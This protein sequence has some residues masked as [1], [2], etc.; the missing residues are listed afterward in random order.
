MSDVPPILKLDTDC[1]DEIFE[2][3]S[4]PDLQSI[5][6]T[7]KALQKAAGLYFWK[8]FESTPKFVESNGIEMPYN[9]EDGPD[10]IRIT[11]GFHQFLK[12]I[13]H[14]YPE[15]ETIEYNKNHNQNFESLNEILLSRYMLDQNIVESLKNILPKI[16]ILRLCGCEIDGDFYENF[17]QF[18]G[19]LK[20]IFVSLEVDKTKHIVNE[21]E[22]NKWMLRKYPTI[23]VFTIETQIPF[24]I[25]ELCWFLTENSTIQTFATTAKM[26]WKNRH[27]LLKSDI[28]LDKLEISMIFED[29]MKM[30]AELLNQLYEI[31]FYKRLKCEISIRDPKTVH[32]LA[33]LRGFKEIYILDLAAECDFS[34]L[35]HLNSLELSD[36][37]EYKRHMNNMATNL[38]NL[39][40]LII[41]EADSNDILPFI[42]RSVKLK[43]IEI[44]S[45][46]GDL[47]LVQLNNE[48]E[49]LA[50]AQ[51]LIIYI[52]DYAFLKTK[53]TITNGNTNLSKIELRRGSFYFFFQ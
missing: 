23:K 35:A 3:L 6:Q 1:C 10:F 4:V 49:K 30:Y 15:P 53:W 25:N 37:Y 22:E 2:Y 9:T 38:V 16:E 21:R 11:T 47:N 41:G 27:E 43:R 28:K 50:D 40:N 8:C 45:F 24:K 33:T 52:G 44:H 39:Q 36:Y 31:G 12:Y 46:N 20:E 32:Q 19:E 51:K 13:K 26:L 42:R 48:R 14:R 29:E 5:G 17:L 34:R 7:C 18:C